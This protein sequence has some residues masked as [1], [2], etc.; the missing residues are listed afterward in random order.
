M[1]NI[2]HLCSLKKHDTWGPDGWKNV[3]VCIVSD[4]RQAVNKNVLD[5]LASLGVYQEGIAKNIVDDKP[6]TAHI[7][8][9]N[10]YIHSMLPF[11]LL[12]IYLHSIPLRSL[13]IRK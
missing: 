5:V 10:I 9:V 3:V 13:S 2:A 6:V 1:K 7:Y 12:N 11:I 4:G 8:E